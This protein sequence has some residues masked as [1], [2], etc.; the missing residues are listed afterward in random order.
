MLRQMI[1]Y[2]MNIFLSMLGI[3]NSINIKV[4]FYRQPLVKINGTKTH[5]KQVYHGE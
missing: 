2:Q 4:D 5:T 3:I 1:Y